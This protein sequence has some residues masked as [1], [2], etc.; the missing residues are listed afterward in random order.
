MDF[1]IKNDI[2]DDNITSR[3]YGWK[4]E[5]IICPTCKNKGEIKVPRGRISYNSM[6]PDC[7]F[8]RKTFRWYV[9]KS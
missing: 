7:K 4:R 6:C 1:K 5:S 3:Y 2:D 8:K 9:L